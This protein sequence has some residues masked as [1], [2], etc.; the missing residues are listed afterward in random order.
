MT[1]TSPWAASQRM[2]DM[3]LDWRGCRR[4]AV[5]WFVQLIVK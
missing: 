2:R 1:M 5:S 4:P 3:V